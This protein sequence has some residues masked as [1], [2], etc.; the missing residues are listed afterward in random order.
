MIKKLLKRIPI[1][2]RIYPSIIKKIYNYINTDEINYEY[3]GLKLKG[4]LKEPMD[5]E[6]FLFSEYEHLQID[7]LLKLMKE[8]K[9]DY[10]IDV[11]ANSGLYSMVVAKNDCKIKI[12]SFEPIKKTILK[13]K[14][15][16][17]LNKN[18]NNIEIFEFGLSNKNSEL[19]MKSLKKK[20]YIQTGGFGVAQSGEI[21]NNLHTEYAE[22]KKGDD[23]FSLENKNIILK[24]D[25]EG[26]EKEVIQGLEN[27]LNKNSIL[28]QIEIFDKNFD[29]MNNILKDKNFNQIHMIKSDGKKDYYYKNY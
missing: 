13:F 22:F 20:N 25:A 16:I 24:I 23:I 11:G 29:V 28:L 15:N 26:H 2:K 1:I 18:L 9:F 19:L 7:Y 5:K 8:S 27:N 6:I 14:E 3:F 10:F 17:Q 21:L 4:N 12:K